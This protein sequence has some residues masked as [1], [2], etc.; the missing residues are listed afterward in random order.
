MV[1]KGFKNLA[2]GMAACMMLSQ[3]FPALALENTEGKWQMEEKAW[4]FVNAKGEKQ[5][6][7]IVS[8]GAWYLLKEDSGTLQSGWWKSPS[9]KWFFF[10]TAHDGSFG[11]LCTGWQWIDGYCYY[12]EDQDSAHLGELLTAGTKDGYSVDEDGRWVENGKPVYEQGKGLLSKEDGQQVAGVSRSI[13]EV[14]GVN[15]SSSGGSGRS[16]G[17]SFGR[18]SGSTSNSANSQ[19]S[20]TEKQKEDA[21]KKA[22]EEKEKEESEKKE[23]EKKEQEEQEKKEGFS[24][25]ERE[26]SGLINL[27]FDK[28]IVLSF[29]EGRPEDYKVEVDGTDITEALTPIDTA[30]KL[31]KWEST[32]VSP[33]NLTISKK[34]GGEEKEILSLNAGEAKAAP[35]VSFESSGDLS[36]VIKGK[37]TKEELNYPAVQAG[38][39]RTK[40]SRTT[41]DLSEQEEKG[42]PITYYFKAFP[43]DYKGENNGKPIKYELLAETEE[44]KKWFEGIDSISSLSEGSIYGLGNKNASLQFT[45]EAVHKTRHG[46]LGVVNIPAG[47]ENLRSKG[48][49]QIKIHSSYDDSTL[50]IPLELVSQDKLVLQQAPESSTPKQGETIR[51]MAEVPG[52]MYLSEFGEPSSKLVLKKPDGSSQK[53]EYL[54]DFYYYDGALLLYGKRKDEEGSLLTDQAGQYVLTVKLNGYGKIKQRFEVF[55][56]EAKEE[57]DEKE[58]KARKRDGEKDRGSFDAISHA[59]SREVLTKKK[60]DLSDLPKLGEGEDKYLSLSYDLL[61]NALLLREL[62]ISNPDADLVAARFLRSRGDKYFLPEGGEQFYDFTGYFAAYKEKTAKS[63]ASYSPAEYLK[64]A[65]AIRKA[66]TALYRVLEDGSLSKE[67]RTEYLTGAKPP[68]FT[69]GVAKPG[70]EIVLETEDREYLKEGEIRAYL[71]KQSFTTEIGSSSMEILEDEGKLLISPKAFKGKAEGE[72][73]LILVREGYQTMEFPLSFKEEAIE[74]QPEERVSASNLSS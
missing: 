17:G 70:E 35:A 41:F 72:H 56:G 36:L 8:E 69:G 18:S 55:A 73:T 26:H 45:K 37:V 49:Y 59:T 15:R 14:L 31:W 64:T 2:I 3:S 67:L 19:Q 39:E 40:E 20:S 38:R 61:S 53:L 32:V 54:K 68:K 7:W 5:K 44:Q 50:T 33:K 58:E 25:L 46:E 6:G 51:F 71:D 74:K 65:E 4:T 52:R 11:K 10:H 48:W 24:V 66:P 23:Q 28:Y 12:F 42:I 60:P 16:S 22:R 29:K 47:Q 57:Q 21:E 43:V 13:P 34:D 9:G 30:G 63:I 62:G 27:G 1:R